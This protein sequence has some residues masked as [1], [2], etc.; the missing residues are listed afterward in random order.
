MK[1]YSALTPSARDRLL[2]GDWRKVIAVDQVV[3]HARVLRLLGE[4]L[5]EDGRRLELV[6]VGLVAR[7]ERHVERERVERPLEIGTSV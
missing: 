3:R 5:L 1:R 6:G 2:V 4:D 7:V